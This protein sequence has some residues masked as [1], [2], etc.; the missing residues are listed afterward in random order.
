[1]CSYISDK[2]RKVTKGA[3]VIEKGVK[4]GTLYIFMDQTIPYTL[5]VAKKN[6]C[7]GIVVIVQWVEN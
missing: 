4:I 7:S 5:V 3:L 6:Q 2:N 1:L